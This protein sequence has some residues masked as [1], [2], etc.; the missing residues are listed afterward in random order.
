MSFDPALRFT[1]LHE[2]GYANDPDDRGGATN[3]GVTQRVYDSYR[4]DLGLLTQDVRKITDTEVTSIYRRRYWDACR[5]DELP[6][7]VAAAVFDT[8][9]NA[10]ADDAIPFLQRALWVADDGRIGP[11]TI[12]AARQRDPRL[13]AWAILTQRRQHHIARSRAA[14]QA[15]FLR[16]WLRRVDDLATLILNSGQEIP[17]RGG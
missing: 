16:G 12:A 5:C 10:G 17:I 13:V 7:P 4:G 2:G 1:L 9:V 11:E 8:A 6:F 3:R 14:G 15:K